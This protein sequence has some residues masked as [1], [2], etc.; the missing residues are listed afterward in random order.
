MRTILI[1]AAM[2]AAYAQP[3]AFEVAAFEI[4]TVKPSEPGIPE[5]SMQ[6]AANTLTLKNMPLRDCILFAWHLQ[7]YQLSGGPAWAARPLG[8]K[9]KSKLMCWVEQSP[10]RKGRYQ[11]RELPNAGGVKKV[12]PVRKGWEPV[13]QNW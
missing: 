4:A 8:E 7:E 5:R 2:A 3:T 12:S 11:L 13:E 1:L 9:A 6:N 10:I